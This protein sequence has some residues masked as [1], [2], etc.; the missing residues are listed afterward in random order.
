[1][2]FKDQWGE[3][4]FTIHNNDGSTFDIVV[5]G[6]VRWALEALIAADKKG[7]TSI[8]TPGPRWSAYVFDLRALGVPIVTHH[9]PHAGAFPGMHARYVLTARV[10][11]AGEAAA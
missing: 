2:A 6:R 4:L 5:S 8:T 11:R 3:S 9:E 10:E 1:M 7:C